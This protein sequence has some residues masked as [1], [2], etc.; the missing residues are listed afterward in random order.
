MQ[1]ALTETTFLYPDCS[2]ISLKVRRDAPPC[3]RASS[4]PVFWPT[5]RVCPDACIAFLPREIQANGPPLHPSNIPPCLPRS[6]RLVL[7]VRHFP[8]GHY[9]FSLPRETMAFFVLG[10]ST[11]KPEYPPVP[12]LPPLRRS[13]TTTSTPATGAQATPPRSRSPLHPPGSREKPPGLGSRTAGTGEAP[14]GHSWAPHSCLV[15]AR[16]S[17]GKPA[18]PGPSRA[19]RLLGSTWEGEEARVGPRGSRPGPRHVVHPRP[20][21]LR[22]DARSRGCGGGGPACVWSPISAGPPAAAP[23]RDEPSR[24]RSLPRFLLRSLPLMRLRRPRCPRAPLSR[25]LCLRTQISICCGRQ[26]PR[27]RRASPHGSPG[28]SGILRCHR[29]TGISYSSLPMI[30]HSLQATPYASSDQ[31]TRYIGTSN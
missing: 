3:S 27:P 20:R 1:L 26:R 10:G 18:G 28:H 13:R 5:H 4:S 9:L 11:G 21:P 7:P 8:G 17:A 15:A 23:R 25:P 31:T 14:G 16:A 19:P 6:E 30:T 12:C 24:A 22:G 2:K 29:G